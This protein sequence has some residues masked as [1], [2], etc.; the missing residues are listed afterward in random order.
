MFYFSEIASD[1]TRSLSTSSFFGALL[2]VLAILAGIIISALV[3]LLLLRIAMVFPPVRSL[4]RSILA[5][6]ET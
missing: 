2:L 1:I 5:R 6:A 3:Q 4:V